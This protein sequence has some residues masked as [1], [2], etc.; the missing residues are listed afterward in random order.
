M[1]R[2]S[3]GAVSFVVILGLALASCNGPSRGSRTQPSSAS[4]LNVILTASP[5]VVR[6]ANPNSDSDDGGAAL[7]Q[8][9]VY[10]QNG[11]LVDGATVFFTT[12]LGV[13]RQGTE[14]FLGLA[15][16][17]TRG[18]ANAAFVA[19]DQVGTATIQAVVEDAVYTTQIT[20]F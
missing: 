3:W 16:V 17:T 8:A 7:V 12:N 5:N 14:D 18:L 9:K 4:G 6:A 11:N 20:I 2:T 13:F 1:R 15:I 10:D 19:Q